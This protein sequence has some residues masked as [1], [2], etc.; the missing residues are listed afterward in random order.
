ME[1]I[2]I[3]YGLGYVEADVC[4]KVKSSFSVSAMTCSVQVM[5]VGCSI[6]PNL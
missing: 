2:Q 1:V 6:S 5:E 3:T 4:E